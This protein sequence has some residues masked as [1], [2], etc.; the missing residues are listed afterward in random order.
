[1]DIGIGPLARFSIEFCRGGYDVTGVDISNTTLNFAKEYIN[2]SNCKNI[3]LIKDDL[4][5][6]KR[7]NEK[8]DLVFCVGTFGHIP[9]FLSIDTLK[10]FNRV[11]KGGSFCIVDIWIKKRMFHI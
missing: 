6:L 9:S 1:M 8:F 4:I 10:S 5:E 3:K 2:R 11:L 7:I